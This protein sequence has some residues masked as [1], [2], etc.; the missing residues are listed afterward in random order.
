M[1]TTSLHNRAAS[2]QSL[3][4]ELVRALSTSYR[5]RVAESVSGADSM[6]LEQMNIPAAKNRR[7]RVVFDIM[8][9]QDVAERKNVHLGAMPAST[10]YRRVA[11]ILGTTWG[12]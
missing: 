3:A 4:A 11:S 9:Y 2:F 12:A 6:G 7:A 10:P 1:R 8:K 5:T